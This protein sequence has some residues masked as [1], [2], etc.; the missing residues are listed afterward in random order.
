[1]GRYNQL[2]ISPQNK[3]E[4]KKMQTEIID[5]INE[6]PKLN[7]NSTIPNINEIRSRQQ[8]RNEEREKQKEL[9]KRKKYLN[10]YVPRYELMALVKILESIK[11]RLF[12]SEILNAALERIIVD[13][14]I[15][16]R[17]EINNAFTFEAKRSQIFT[18]INNNTNN[19]DD[20]ITQCTEYEIDINVTS[21]PQQILD[22]AILTDEQK[23]SYALSNNIQILLD[24]FSDKINSQEQS[25]LILFPDKKIILME[26]QPAKELIL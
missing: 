1:M 11:Q 17:D 26:Q 22:D 3:K 25:N 24:H 10:S 19:Y 8:N 6:M 2:I 23:I 7:G 13:N 21:I 18:E 5:E 16:T 15:A 9:E 14:K 4:H 20:R 12:Q